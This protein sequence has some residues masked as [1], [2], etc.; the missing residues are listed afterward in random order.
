FIPTTIL[1]VTQSTDGPSVLSR[2][3]GA[4][5]EKQRMGGDSN[6]R[7]LSAHTLSRRAQSTA[8][9]PIQNNPPLPLNPPLRGSSDDPNRVKLRGSG[10]GRLSHL[11][12]P[13][14]FVQR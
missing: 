12:A 1:K 10:R 9:S 4:G 7:C 11:Q 8:L 14:Q 6:P 13:E 3:G 2:S 5:W